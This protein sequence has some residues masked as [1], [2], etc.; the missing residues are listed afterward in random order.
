[1]PKPKPQVLLRTAANYLKAHP[2]EIIRAIRGAIGLRV[3][4]PLDAFRWFVAEFAQG[5]KAP[6]DVIIEAAPPGLRLALT[7]AAMGTTL[8]VRLTLAVEELD[9]G[10]EKALVTARISDMELEVLD[11]ADTPVAGLIK[12]GALDL[13]KP[14][15]LVAYMPKRPEMLVEAK[16]DR[17]VIDLLKV[18]KIA[19]NPKARKMLEVLTPVLTVGSIKTMDDH[20]DVHFK[21]SPSR[22]A[23]AIAAAQSAA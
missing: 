23:E 15:N 9:L 2:E 18:P 22:I 20:L 1:M 7:V 17:V 4:I 11:G 14:G 8:R 12:S 6:K 13:S 21:A 10:G 16:D 19:N 3:G 5:K